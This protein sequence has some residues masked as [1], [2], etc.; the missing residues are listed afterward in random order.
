M[1][2]RQSSEDVDM[3][4][5]S[6]MSPR[7]EVPEKDLR[8]SPDA[9]SAVISSNLA[10]LRIS[11]SRGPLFP[12]STKSPT[13]ADAS[14]KNTS[15]PLEPSGGQQDGKK[16]Y[17]WNSMA[18]MIKAHIGEL[19]ARPPLGTPKEDTKQSGK[20]DGGSQQTSGSGGGAESK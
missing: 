7:S 15:S 20:G 5:P 1:E 13:M 18:E 8:T 12:T 14:D 11:S 3:T 6:P 2:D 4:S 19:K 9:S 17:R 16:A 10:N